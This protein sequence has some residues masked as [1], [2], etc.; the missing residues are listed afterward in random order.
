LAVAS[1]ETGAS[2]KAMATAFDV[3]VG[4]GDDAGEDGVV[5]VGADDDADRRW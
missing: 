1:A 5:G 3:G 2:S 4:V